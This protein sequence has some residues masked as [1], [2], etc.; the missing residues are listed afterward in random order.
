MISIIVNSLFYSLFAFDKSFDIGFV[1][2]NLTFDLLL[3]PN[4]IVINQK[5]RGSIV[6]LFLLC[7]KR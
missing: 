2:L 4:L 7:K 3:L 1:I 5:K 6:S